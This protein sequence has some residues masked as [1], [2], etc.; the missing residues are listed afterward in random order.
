MYS[1]EK[2]TTYDDTCCDGRKNDSLAQKSNYLILRSS[3][4][5]KL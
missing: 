3:F 5:M 4:P 1:R 2:K